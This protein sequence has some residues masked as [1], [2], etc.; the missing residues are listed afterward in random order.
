LNTKKLA[1]TIVFAAMAIAL[2]PA[3]THLAFPAPFDPGLF[4]QLWE[5][6][7]IVALLI[8]S[9]ISSIAV[10]ILNTSVLLVLFP[11]ALPTGPLYNMLACLS[12]QVGIYTAI[13]IGKKVYNR[14]N[15]QTSNIL[16]SIKWLTIATGLGI[17]TR[18]SFMTVIHYF[19]LPQP[20]PIG[21]GLNYAL[22]N[23]FLPLSAVFNATLA[24]YTIPIAWIIA[25]QVQKVLQLNI[26]SSI[27]KN[28][29]TKN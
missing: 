19:A 25:R 9:P 16:T 24:L 7:I 17:L 4:Y 1:L 29:V 6:P 14:K 22:I 21:F 15:L 5:I 18:T 11:G 23:A 12:M 20:P 10:C 28:S 8:I 3:I 2:N 26:S 27:P 13:T